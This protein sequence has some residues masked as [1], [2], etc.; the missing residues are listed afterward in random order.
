MVDTTNKRFPHTF[1]VFRIEIS[2]DN[3]NPIEEKKEILS[4]ICRAFPPS[5]FTSKNKQESNVFVSDYAISFPREVALE[6]VNR[7]DTVITNDIIE[8]N[9]VDRTFVGYITSWHV[10]G[11]GAN[12]WFNETKN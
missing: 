9:S 2:G 1:K 11:L 12:I 5:G 10:S 7:K 8:I 4:G 3:A 6:L